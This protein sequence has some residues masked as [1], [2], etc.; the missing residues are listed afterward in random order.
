MAGDPPPCFVRWRRAGVAEDQERVARGGC[1]RLALLWSASGRVRVPTRITVGLQKTKPDLAQ[2]RKG[3]DRVPKPGERDLAGDGDGGGMDQ[4][5][6]ARTDE[7][8]P[9]HDLARTVDD[10]LARTRVPLPERGGR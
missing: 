2:G 8:S 6:G 9:H 1:H 7:G 5:R 10:Q 3:G 4:L